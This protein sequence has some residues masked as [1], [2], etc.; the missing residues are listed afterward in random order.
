MNEGFHM[1]FNSH[2]KMEHR[3]NHKRKSTKEN[4]VVNDYIY[5]MR[6]VVVVYSCLPMPVHGLLLECHNRADEGTLGLYRD[7]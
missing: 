5:R 3:V 2:R 4:A 1:I 7:G 6:A